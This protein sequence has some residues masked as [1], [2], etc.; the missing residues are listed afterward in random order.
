MRLTG[1]EN[2]IKRAK[3]LRSRMSLPEVILWQ[4]LRKR[5]N[6]M[7]FRRQHPAGA[8]ILDFYCDAAKL[9]IE[10]DGE[11]HAFRSKHDQRHDEWL[12]QQG[13]TVVRILARDVL[14]DLDAVVRYIASY[15]P[16]AA[17]PA[18]PPPTG[19]DLC[20]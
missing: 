1:P 20:N 7:R 13:V 10:V 18:A 16:S 8:Y 15:T 11:T 9:C 17:V 5:Q 19:E 2:T 6:G 14:H 12:R 4:E 3:R